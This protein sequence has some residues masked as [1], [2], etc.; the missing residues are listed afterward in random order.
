[1][2]SDSE[3]GFSSPEDRSLLNLRKLIIWHIMKIS[4]LDEDVISEY[5]DMLRT[6]ANDT[7]FQLYFK[8]MKIVDISAQLEVY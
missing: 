4:N 5:I 8:A 1:M 7:A 6:M 3:D 2:V